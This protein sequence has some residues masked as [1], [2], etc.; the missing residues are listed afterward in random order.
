MSSAYH[1][2]SSKRV[3]KLSR[4]S[5]VYKRPNLRSIRIL[6]ETLYSSNVLISDIVTHCSFLFTY[7]GYIFNST[8]TYF[9]R[10]PCVRRHNIVEQF[11]SLLRSRH[12]E[13][14]VRIC[15]LTRNECRATCALWLPALTTVKIQL[16]CYDI[17]VIKLYRDTERKDFYRYTRPSISL[18]INWCNSWNSTLTS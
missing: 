5:N 2:R 12:L 15:G 7:Y 14:L 17:S 13:N 6:Y 9:K 18:C 1:F 8:T 10:K 16:M 4:S 11:N 3:A